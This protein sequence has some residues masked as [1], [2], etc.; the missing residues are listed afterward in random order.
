[1]FSNRE[2]CKGYGKANKAFHHIIEYQKEVT[3][4]W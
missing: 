3:R 1:V 2:S 4:V